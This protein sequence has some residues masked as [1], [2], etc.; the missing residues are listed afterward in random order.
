M[1]ADRDS[2]WRGA[3]P[4]RPTDTPHRP[5]REHVRRCGRDLGPIEAAYQLYREALADIAELAANADDLVNATHFGC[6]ATSGH[7]LA[8]EYRRAKGLVHYW[9][10]REQE[11]DR[12]EP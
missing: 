5:D 3:D 8:K 10:E 1:T 4:N 2:T 9:R 7:P 6:L 12:E 11:C